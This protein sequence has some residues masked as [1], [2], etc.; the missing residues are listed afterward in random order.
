[1]DL[2]YSVEQEMLRANVGRYCRDRLGRK[3]LPPHDVAFSREH[4]TAFAHMDWL[5]VL[6]P[7]DVGG[8]NGSIIDACIIL[9][10]F[11]RHLV[12]QPYLPGAVLA[13]RTIERATNTEQRRALLR[14]MV[15]G[16]L[17]VS[18]A[19]TESA[20]R[21]ETACVET[22]AHRRSSG[23]YVLQ[24]KKDLV[25][26]GPVADKFAVSAR[27]ASESGERGG[28]A[29][30]LI[31][32]NA[33]GMCRRDYQTIDERCA[34]D[35]TLEEVTVGEDSLLIS[36]ELGL[37]AIEEAIDLATIGFCAEADGAM[38]QIIK[39]TAEY[40]KTRRAYGSTLN[41][42]QALQH[43]LADMLVELELSRSMLY[44]A[45]AAFSG[46][47]LAERRRAVSSAK[48]LIGRSARFVASNGIQLHGAQGMVD[49]YVIGQ[50]FKQLTMIE[51]VFGCS[52]FHWEQCALHLGDESFLVD[53]T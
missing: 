42:F 18:L 12:V 27:V 39:V 4:W 33:P 29:V 38:D 1:M 53:R 9:E 6:L 23:E 45:F 34:A 30:F 26:A 11:G 17:M 2:S 16:E 24:G 51:A 40:L 50:H 31:D 49:D 19:H 43:R 41:T 20:A 21:G 5:G 37:P 7:E 15:R 47:N 52:D 13:A 48:A 22:A 36:E 3:S 25:L 44:C 28:I 35:L 14:P 8:I 46:S 32:R 10:E